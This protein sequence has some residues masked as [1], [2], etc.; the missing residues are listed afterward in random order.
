MR[1]DRF[2]ARGPRETKSGVQNTRARRGGEIRER[3]RIRIPR[4]S[5]PLLGE[6]AS[7]LMSR[8]L[9]D[10]PGIV[11]SRRVRR[12]GLIFSENFPG[13]AAASCNGKI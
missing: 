10:T 7:A 8:T 12:S 9:N 13:A 2:H 4:T 3:R 11:F 5:L 6:V 1:K